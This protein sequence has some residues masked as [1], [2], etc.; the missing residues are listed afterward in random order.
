MSLT[1]VG[2]GYRAFRD[3]TRPM[4][5]AIVFLS[6]AVANFVLGVLLSALLDR[7]SSAATRR[8][9]WARRHC[10]SIV[11]MVRLSSI[12]FSGAHTKTARRPQPASTMPAIV[13]VG[14]AAVACV[15]ASSPPGQFRA[16][17]VVLALTPFMAIAY[18]QRLFRPHARARPGP[19]FRRAGATRHSLTFTVV[20]GVAAA[21]RSAAP[22]IA[23]LD[24]DDAYFRC[25]ARA[26]A[27]ARRGPC[28]RQLAGHRAVCGLLQAGR[29]L[30]GHLSHDQ[31]FRP[32]SRARTV[33]SGGDGL[34]LALAD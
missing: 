22:V 9:R 31:P 29:R 19:R 6:N 3:E 13:M 34:E 2:R 20:I 11:S 24:S 1:L 16:R 15:L 4:V 14:V 25:R 32:P 27:H 7:R 21:A 33:R 30:D 8:W 18:A 12:R 17:R 5:F 28:A 23:A 26:H 10:D